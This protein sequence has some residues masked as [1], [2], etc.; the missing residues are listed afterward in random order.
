MTHQTPHLLTKGELRRV[1]ECAKENGTF[2]ECWNSDQVVIVG[3]EPVGAHVCVTETPF[4]ELD[5]LSPTA[6]PLSG[7]KSNK[8]HPTRQCC[9]KKFIVLEKSKVNKRLRPK[10]WYYR[11][12]STEEFSLYYDDAKAKVKEL[13]SQLATEITTMV[14][15][16]G[17]PI[18]SFRSHLPGTLFIMQLKSFLVAASMVASAFAKRTCGTDEP[19]EVDLQVAQDFKLMESSARLAGNGSRAAGPIQINVYWHVVASSQSVSGGY[20]TQ[21]T[22]DEQLA[23]LNTAYAP[24][25]IS[26][27][28]VGA[29]WTVN[30]NWAADR[31]E[32]AMKTALRKG[33]YADLNVYFV[34]S[35]RYLGYARFPQTITPGSADFNR[36]GVVILSTTV[37][38]GSYEE[39]SL[40]HT[41]THEIGHWL[42]LFHTFQGYA[43]SGDGDSVD[44]TPYEAEESYGCQ[45]G[46][47]T[48]PNSAGTDSVT[49]YMNYSDDEC[50]TGF[51]NGQQSRIYSYWDTYR[52]Q[53]Q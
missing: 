14:L 2:A 24:H 4:M 52:A 36:D 12:D 38:G 25:D 8:Q 21:A 43:C 35:S 28:E 29:D 30:S 27:V 7:S 16:I 15:T 34:A 3:C 40:G 17:I 11:Y 5:I 42:G 37:P 1:E 53:Y 41:A 47:D 49:N 45:I 44:D 51:S 10:P 46:R 31:A 9:K 48:C 6:N 18:F 33:T 19:T 32:V 26:F 39:Y 50:F 23:V 22:L 13:F 20:L